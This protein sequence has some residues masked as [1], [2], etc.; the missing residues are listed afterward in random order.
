MLAATDEEAQA[1]VDEYMKYSILEGSLAKFCGISGIDLAKWGLDDEF[2]TDPEHPSLSHLNAKQKE[3]LI[4]RPDGYENWTPRILGE[5][6]AIGGSSALQ[7]GS[8]ET[9]ADEMERWIRIADVD[10][11]NIG[12]V[13][14]PQAWV[15][16]VEFLVP[17]LEKRGWLGNVNEYSV[18]GGTLRE[19]LYATPGDSRLRSSHPGSTFK[20][21]VFQDAS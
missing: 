10:G 4:N 1:K 13:V 3:T 15:D 17:V 9:V 7:V 5:Y 12:H 11:F 19:N 21:G 2:P 16:V 6:S 18:P 14:V 20:F 8:G